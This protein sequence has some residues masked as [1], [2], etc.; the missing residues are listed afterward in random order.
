MLIA[1]AAVPL[2]AG[3]LFSGNWNWSIALFVVVPFFA[4]MRGIAVRLRGMFLDAVRR[5]RDV[6]R[7]AAQFDSALNNMPCGLAMLDVQGRVVVT[8]RR[9]S[10]LLKIPHDAGRNARTSANCSPPASTPGSLIV[11]KR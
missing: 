6:S 9:L 10:E 5:A 1:C 8:N 2:L 7:L 3:L 11:V 4:A